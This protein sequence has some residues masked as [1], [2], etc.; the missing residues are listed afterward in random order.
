MAA[1]LVVMVVV[2]VVLGPGHHFGSHDSHGS[3]G[4]EAKTHQHDNEQEKPSSENP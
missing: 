1:M 3:K 2:L 4:Q